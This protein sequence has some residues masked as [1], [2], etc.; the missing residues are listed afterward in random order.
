MF[1][2][3]I[4]G[5]TLRKLSHQNMAGRVLNSRKWFNLIELHLNLALWYDAVT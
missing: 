1:Q 3:N 5:V 4:I 2:K